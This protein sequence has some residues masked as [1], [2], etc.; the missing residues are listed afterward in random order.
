MRERIHHVSGM[1]HTNLLWP[2]GPRNSRS[3]C[4]GL[5]SYPTRASVN[6]MRQII[7][8]VLEGELQ[9]GTYQVRQADCIAKGTRPFRKTPCLTL[10]QYCPAARPRRD[11]DGG[12][13]HLLVTHSRW[14]LV[15]VESD[16]QVLRGRADQGRT[17]RLV[18]LADAY[19]VA[20]VVVAHEI[21]VR[22]I[23]EIH[24]SRSDLGNLGSGGKAG[25]HK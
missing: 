11:E 13:Y 1:N 16:R 21:R 4:Y 2:H 6:T 24:E 10:L 9:G 20:G 17:D 14:I 22:D 15:L 25:H 5:L 19:C 3:R 12:R 18:Q 8:G 7:R 23:E